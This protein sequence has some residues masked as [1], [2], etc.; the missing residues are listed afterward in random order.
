MWGSSAYA[1]MLQ[2][3]ET[4]S[5]SV[6]E[7]LCFYSCAKVFILMHVCCQTAVTQQF[8]ILRDEEEQAFV[9][10]TGGHALGLKCASSILK[11]VI[12]ISNDGASV[13][14]I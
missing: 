2:E 9:S 12:V 7:G 6:D 1:N 10:Q 13:E 4:C 3:E 14:D 8:N 5:P 11:Y